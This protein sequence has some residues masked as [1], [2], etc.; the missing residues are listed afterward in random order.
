MEWVIFFKLSRSSM[1]LI[2]FINIEFDGISASY[3]ACVLLTLFK[4]LGGKMTTKL[5]LFI[6]Y[7]YTQEEILSFSTLTIMTIV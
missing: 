2:C 7:E 3:F 1:T 5:N 6:T 4:F